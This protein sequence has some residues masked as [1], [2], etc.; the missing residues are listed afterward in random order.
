MLKA[1]P[2]FAYLLFLTIREINDK[3]TMYS[4]EFSFIDRKNV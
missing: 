4:S 2:R 1:I 3:A